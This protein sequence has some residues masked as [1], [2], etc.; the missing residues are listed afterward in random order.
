MKFVFRPVS[1]DVCGSFEDRVA[2]LR[3]DGR[4]YPD[5]VN[6][7][8]QYKNWNL[9]FESSVL[10]IRN[11]RP[12]VFFQGTGGTLDLA[13]DGYTFQPNKGPAVS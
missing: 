1:D 13:R 10:P 4:Q 7:I 11:E 3:P 2:F 6:A 8:S 9:S 12:S 5:K